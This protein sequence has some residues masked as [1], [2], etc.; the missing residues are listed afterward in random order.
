MAALT[1]PNL[2]VKYRHKVLET[3]FKKAYS[4]L[5]NA[6]K[7]TY[8][9]DVTVYSGTPHSNPEFFQEI[10]KNYKGAKKISTPNMPFSSTKYNQVIKDY[11]RT[12]VAKK[13]ECAQYPGTLY[14]LEDGSLMSA[15][16]NCGNLRIGMDINGINPP[17]AYGHD[18]FFFTV[19]NE[20]AF[21]PMTSE[22][23]VK[24]DE[25]GKSIGYNYDSSVSNKCSKNAA[26][27]INGSTCTRFAVLNR[28]PDDASKGY[29]DCLP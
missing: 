2:I 3:S 14:Q 27:L 12:K 17:N 22:T 24:Y 23:E 21:A 18:I 7:K 13:L 8:N 20:G 15:M 16:G 1:I 11:S 28:C 29:W 10:M 4:N 9:E 25:N 6:V 19:S 26:S 5:A